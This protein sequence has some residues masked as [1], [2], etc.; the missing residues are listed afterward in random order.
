VGEPSDRPD[1]AQALFDEM[2]Q[3]GVEV[4]HLNPNNLPQA[5]AIVSK[6]RTRLDELQALVRDEGEELVHKAWT[7][8]L[9]S[10][11]AAWWRDSRKGV[12]LLASFFV[13][14]H[15]RGFA[16]AA[17]EAELA[18]THARDQGKPWLE[19]CETPPWPTRNQDEAEDF[20]SAKSWEVDQ[21]RSLIRSA[22]AGWPEF[23]LWLAPRV[24][25]PDQVI[26]TLREAA[27]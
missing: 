10:E 14:R 19:P 18:E 27:A 3:L 13:R 23:K 2:M 7:Y 24:S 6:T 8:A 1:P 17:Q 26:T 25:D 5:D 16:D 11:D 12:K 9:T 4:G 15:F 21:M 20:L 22:G